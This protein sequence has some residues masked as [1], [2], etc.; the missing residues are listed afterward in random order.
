MAVS[1]HA[2]TP[3]VGVRAWRLTLPL[4][5]LA[6]LGCSGKSGTQPI[7][8][9]LQST[10]GD[11][12]GLPLRYGAQL[13]A[14]EINAQGGIHGRP[15]EFIEAD[16][17]G[18]SDSA[19]AAANRLVQSDVVA[20]I[21]GAFSG[22]TLAAAP[23]YNDPT[24]PIVEISP[25]AS[26]PEVTFA[27][28]WTFRVCAGDLAHAA[29]LA[30]F[31]RQQLNLTR[32]AVLYMDNQYG[33]GFRDVFASEFKRLGGQVLLTGPYLADRPADTGPY[34]DLIK[35]SGQVQ[36]LLAASYE[37]DGAELLKQMRKRGLD[38]PLLGGDGLEGL[39]REGAI[40]DGSY[41]TAA[42]L[43]ALATPENQAFVQRYRQAFPAI[44]PPNQTAAATYDIV[45]LLAR[46]IGNVGTG[47]KAIR[48]ALAQVGGKRPVFIG[49]TGPIQFD[50]NGD[51]PT[52]KVLIAMI[53]G[54][55]VH[56]VEGQ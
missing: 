15:I 38:I 26:S 23:V 49:V 33:R 46:V 54:G 13:A 32:G 8:I 10:F 35:K 36:F 24:H 2:S 45:N 52:K 47:R 53:K 44:A 20:V 43:P 55:S 25:S 51:V 34:F 30:S 12:L 19:V 4:L 39:Q 27:G 16:D 3:L 41:Q 14:Q 5:L 7:K 1:S 37:T 9:G 17:Y 31:V 50:T 11:P 40:A 48:N 18:S 22:P 29:R 42:Y 28:D 6:A 56:L 21:G